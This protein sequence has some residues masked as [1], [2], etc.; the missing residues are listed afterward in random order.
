MLTKDD[1]TLKWY[2]IVLL[3][4]SEVGGAPNQRP[5]CE[6]RVVLFRG[7]SDEQ[8]ALVARQYA[9]AEQ[10]SYEN[11]EGETV[12]WRFERVERMD[13][14]DERREDQPW[15]VFSRYTRRSLAALRRGK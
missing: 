8:V 7:K 2:S 10:H 13:V 3:F 6:E 1:T 11:A 15:E 12:D 5:L 4:R 14:L 9:Q